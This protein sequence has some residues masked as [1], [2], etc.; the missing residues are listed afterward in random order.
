MNTKRHVFNVIPNAVRDLTLCI[1][2]MISR[3]FLLILT[4]ILTTSCINDNNT[5]AADDDGFTC[6]QYRRCSS[7]G[8]V[9]NYSDNMCIRIALC[10]AQGKVAA[11]GSCQVCG[12]GYKTGLETCDDGPEGSAT[13][14]IACTTSVCNDGIINIKADEE[15]DDGVANGKEY[16]GCTK[17]CKIAPFCGDHEINGPEVC[18]DGPG[19][20]D[21]WTLTKHC[22]KD[23]SGFAP[24]CGDK[25]INGL[26]KCDDGIANSDEWS[27]SPHCNGSCSGGANYC[28]D[29]SE[30]SLQ[31]CDDN[32]ACTTD[33]CI[34]DVGCQNVFDAAICNKLAFVTQPEAEQFRSAPWAPFSV[35][36]L[37]THNNI[38][39][40][41]NA[42]VALS[43]TSGSGKLIGNQTV[44]AVNGIAT[45]N[46]IAYDTQEDGVKISA[47]VHLIGQ[48]E[49]IPVK[50]THSS[51]AMVSSGNLHTCA[52]TKAGEL[53]CW[54]NN[55]NGQL[56]DGT[57]E[58]KII[59]VRIGN[60]Y[61]QFITTGFYYSCGI[62]KDHTLWC[63]G[64]YG[65]NLGLDNENNTDVN[66]PKQVGSDNNWQSVVASS[67]HTCGLKNNAEL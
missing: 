42:T 14:T 20:G 9:C 22:K 33:S 64:K 51:L 6:D 2:Q 49:S 24:Y 7:E 50:V 37:D 23:C 12:D 52:I 45:F 65:E 54:G 1:K 58:N 29:G 39:S 44:D 59:P 3:I 34:K 16:D 63:W 36:V 35:A 32:D 27:L 17:E 25:D 66:T 61:W 26:E 41:A 60:E 4:I 55:Y 47:S 11:D 57:F 43:V 38:V 19:N 40:G 31:K 67:S 48:V 15:C 5:A 28:G 18:D 53:W 13:C 30:Q 62:K 56:G 46:D 8:Y 10:E 21:N